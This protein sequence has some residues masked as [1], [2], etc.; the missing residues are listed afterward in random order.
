M[1]N[2]EKRIRNGRLAHANLVLQSCMNY[3]SG[4]KEPYRQDPQDKKYYCTGC[5]E[6]KEY[7][8]KDRICPVFIFQQ[9]M[10]EI[11][12]QADMKDRKDLDLKD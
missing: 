4:L 2:F 5:G 11:N 9:I 10:D 1:E 6:V 8:H 7:G 12:F 3:A